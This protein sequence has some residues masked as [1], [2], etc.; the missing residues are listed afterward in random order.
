[1]EEKITENVE[2]EVVAEANEI[3]QGELNEENNRE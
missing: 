1:M 3:N 2:P